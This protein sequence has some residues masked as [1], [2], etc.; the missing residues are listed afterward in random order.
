M[1]G[2]A[3]GCRDSYDFR[4]ADELVRFAQIHQMKVRGH[5]L[6]WGRYNPDW[7]TQGHFTTQQL[8]TASPRTHHSRDEH[9]AGQVFAWDVI[10]EALDEKGNVRDSLWYNQPGIGFSKQGTR[11]IEQ[12]FRWAHEAD[13]KALLFYNE[14]EGEGAEP[15]V[16][17][18]LRHDQRFPQPGVPIHGVG[19]QMHVPL[20][21]ADIPAIAA[22]IARLTALGCRFTSPSL[23]FLCR[24]FQRKGSNGGSDPS[25]RDLSRHRPS[26]PG[27]SGLHGDP[28]LGIHGQVLM[29]WFSLARRSRRR[30][31]LSIEPVSRR[32]PTAR[33]WRRCWGASSRALI[34]QPVEI[35]FL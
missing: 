25:G 5:C 11:Y 21:D 32:P 14:A 23:T 29:D 20:L 33:C 8:L 3:A 2:A 12:V 18:D 7:L 10:N 27:Q 9:Y 35:A 13:P 26:M 15:Q 4:Q 34:W 31:C 24:G 1:V 19:L 16:G 28:D 17:R 6:V 22:N 30:R